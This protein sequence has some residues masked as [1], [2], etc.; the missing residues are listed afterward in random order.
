VLEHAAVSR[1]HYQAEHEVHDFAV[2][3]RWWDAALRPSAK[4][5]AAHSSHTTLHGHSS[6]DLQTHHHHDYN[7]RRELLRSEF[8]TFCSELR[9][10]REKLEAAEDHGKLEKFDRLW[11]LD[12]RGFFAPAPHSQA[13]LG[14]CREAVSGHS[15]SS[16]SNVAGK[17]RAFFSLAEAHEEVETELRRIKAMPQGSADVAKR[18]V[19]LFQCDLL[20]GLQGRLLRRKQQQDN[21]SPV[22]VTLGKKFA[23]ATVLFCINA[24][25]LFYSLLFGLQQSESRQT[26]WL[27]SFVL[28]LVVEVCLNSTLCVI[29]NHVLLP[30]LASADLRELNLRLEAALVAVRE[31]EEQHRLKPG[32]SMYHLRDSMQ[33][34]KR[35]DFNA[36]DYFLVSSRLARSPACRD[37]IEARL[38]R[39]FSTPFPPLHSD[40]KLSDPY[41]GAATGAWHALSV[42]AVMALT[43]LLNLP[44]PA[45]SAV[46]D[47]SVSG[48]AFYSLYLLARLWAISPL[49]ACAPLLLIAFL[50]YKACGRGYGWCEKQRRGE[51]PASYGGG[52][53]REDHSLKPLAVLADLNCSAAFLSSDQKQVFLEQVDL[54]D[55]SEDEEED[56]DGEEEGGLEEIDENGVEGNDD[57]GND[58]EERKEGKSE[59]ERESESNGEVKSRKASLGLLSVS[60]GVERSDGGEKS[61]KDKEAE[62]EA[63][64][65]SIGGEEG[66][67]VAR[68]PLRRFS[69]ETAAEAEAEE[70]DARAYLFG[71]R[72]IASASLHPDSPDS[73]L[74]GLRASM[75][76]TDQ[77]AEIKAEYERD[78]ARLEH[79]IEHEHADEQRTLQARLKQKLNY[80]DQTAEIKAEYERDI[81]RLE[82][83]IEHEHADEQRTLQARLKQKRHS[84]DIALLGGYVDDD[85]PD[86]PMHTVSPMPQDK[87]KGK[88]GYN[89]RLWPDTLQTE[90]GGGGGGGGGGHLTP[91][92]QARRA[93]LL[94]GISA[95]VLLCLCSSVFFLLSLFLLLTFSSFFFL[96][97]LFLLPSLLVS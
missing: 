28:W 22:V 19:F 85:H 57:E 43:V 81:A 41:R 95:C 14:S 84:A 39:K 91:L 12:E 64:K 67:A 17:E 35:A 61:E 59:S 8:E 72:A 37:K 60:E 13:W 68:Q 27:L 29:L 34:E 38:V 80:A 90:G 88:E 46:V 33:I 20:P 78:I 77:T 79:D 87:D 9:Q 32:R 76:Y 3:E 15:S 24:F 7:L 4:G 45:Q 25:M 75:N 10:Y 30:G 23:G 56:E 44:D 50:A 5:S 82:Q 18:L 83:D 11:L 40:F 71:R 65:A 94:V 48:G 55:S 49:L 47:L 2:E 97:S 31:E 69:T 92:Q 73:A 93:S 62:K 58:D 96:L 36:A 26:A 51:G 89:S 54:S 21:P 70:A 86:A 66:A 74:G 53:D 16:S 63:K 6:A 42:A 1:R 52:S